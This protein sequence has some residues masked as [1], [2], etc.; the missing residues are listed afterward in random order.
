M[1]LETIGVIALFLIV[2]TILYYFTRALFSPWNVTLGVW[3]FV[4]LLYVTIDH[5]LYEIK[6][7]VLYA[8]LIWCPALSL[9]SYISY[10]IT[11]KNTQ[12][13]WMPCEKNID[14]LTYISFFVVPFG[15]YKAFQNA[16]LIGSPDDLFYT[17]RQQAID[18]EL[19]NIGPVRYFLYIVYPLFIIEANRLKIRKLRFIFTFS[20]CFIFFLMTMAKITFF[21]IAVSSMYLLYKNKKI[22][23]K[24]II[25]FF[26]SFLLFAV[27]LQVIRSNNTEANGESVMWFLAVYIISPLQ[28]FCTDIAHSSLYWGESTFRGIFHIIH[29]FGFNVREVDTLDQFVWVPL[30]TNVYS[31]MSPY[32]RDF[33]YWGI[34]I[35]ALIE[36]TLFGYIYKK[37][38]T[39]NTIL[40]YVYTLIL[41]YLFLQFFDEQFMKNFI[42]NI[43]IIFTTLFCHI[44]FNFSSKQ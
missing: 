41:V 43:Y 34:F 17:I 24:P 10:I 23:I 30:P 13:K 4:L 38:M 40:E 33:G 9:S 16:M 36:G 18:P 7:Q 2:L 5:G 8:L 15:A 35:F 31:V 11:P 27:I 14:I 22:S 44:Q 6:P 26:L 19:Y 25:I 1:Y 29:T 42:G 32:F 39:G 28:A 37:S 20:L 3:A 21:M 12:A